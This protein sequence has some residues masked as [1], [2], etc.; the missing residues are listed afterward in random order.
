MRPRLPIRQWLWPWL[1]PLLWMASACVSP[2][3]HKNVPAFAN[4]V[5]LSTEKRNP[6]SMPWIGNMKMYKQ[7]ELSLL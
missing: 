5:M 2:A 6:P 3:V 1:L 4:A 7:K